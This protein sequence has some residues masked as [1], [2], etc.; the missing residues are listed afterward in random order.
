LSE[1]TVR[2]LGELVDF[3]GGGT[4]SRGVTDYW[5]EDEV[6]WVSPKDMKRW[7]IFD[8]EEHITEKG[9][10]ESAVR[11]IEPGSV[12]VV[13]RGM[14]LIRHFPIGLARVRLTINQDM[15]ALVSKGEMLPEFI[16]YA[17]AAREPYVLSRIETAS[18]GTKRL[19]TSTLKSV[20]VP[21]PPLDEQARLVDRLDGAFTRLEAVT[22]LASQIVASE[23]PLRA[24]LVQAALVGRL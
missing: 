2:R 20:P 1:W 17:L 15:K 8:S 4:P 3:V 5:S 22:S 10:A 6:P 9:V 12:L 16:A 18:H 14:I 13:V 24:S 21:C 23:V 7:N 11:W 19:P